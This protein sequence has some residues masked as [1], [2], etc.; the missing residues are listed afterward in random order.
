MH[1]NRN[2][3]NISQLSEK[4]F[5][6]IFDLVDSGRNR[7]GRNVWKFTEIGSVNNLRDL[8]RFCALALEA[9]C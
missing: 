9:P 8:I 7:R 2:R 6:G 5:E 1:Q 3:K 4:L